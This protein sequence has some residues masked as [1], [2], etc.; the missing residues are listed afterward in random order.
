MSDQISE[1]LETAGAVQIMAN[2]S[3]EQTQDVGQRLEREIAECERVQ[4]AL[5]ASIGEFQDFVHVASHDLREPLRKITSF[6]LLLKESL[7][8]KLEGE[9]REN[10]EFMV[11]GARRMTR[12]L[13]DL[14]TYSRLNARVI[15]PETVDLN[16]LVEQ[17]KGIELAELLEETGAIIEVPQSLPKVQADPVLVKT[18]VQNLVVNGIQYCGKDVL[19]QISMRVGRLADDKVTIGVQ[20]NGIGIDE[21]YHEHIVKIF[22]RL[23]AREEGAG[24]GIGLAICKKIL[25]KHGGRLEVDS[26]VATGSTFW[27]TLPAA[28]R[29]E[30]EQD[31]LVS[32]A[33]A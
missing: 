12:M 17:L 24:T 4:G 20:D 21:K 7:E 29:L 33:S 27:L 9:D 28:T 18:L 30:Q 19:P 3:T 15:K 10:L 5:D 13:E 26:H 16:Q 25:D 11:D 8:G 23:Q 31:R 22:T 2:A 1:Q 6:G 14:L 32:S